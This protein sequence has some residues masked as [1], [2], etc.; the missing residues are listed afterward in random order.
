MI[1]L[2]N[3][4]HET[5]WGGEKLIP[6]ASEKREK[7]GHLYTLCS[8]KGLETRIINGPYQGKTVD[9]YFEE[10]R[11][12]LGL[13]QYERF[14]FVL[15]LVEAKADLSIQVH[16]DDEMAASAEGADYGKNESWYFL[17]APDSGYIF[18][19]CLAQSREEVRE[20]LL[21]GQ[22]MSVVDHLEVSPGDYVYVQ[23]GTLHAMS[24]GSVVY[25]IEENSPWTYRLYDYDRVDSFGNRRELHIEKGVRAL[26]ADLKSSAYPMGGK[27]I[28]ER[29]YRLLKLADVSRYQNTSH[30]IQCITMIQGECVSGDMLCTAG[31]S[32]ILEP[33]EVIG[34]RIDLA[35][36]AEPK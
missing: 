17:N 1:V 19:G 23:A 22:M 36:V 6:F 26:H 32:A 12:R 7:I 9:E 3:A 24:A 27:W 28:E 21:S 16:P 13:S 2:R 30:M 33:G 35:I 31:Q 10:N 34:G 5:V 11:D 14:P 8:E 15:A 29:S 18:N 20:K 25:E 4:S